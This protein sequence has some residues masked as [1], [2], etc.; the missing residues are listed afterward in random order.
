MSLM[1][2]RIQRPWTSTA[3][4]PLARTGVTGVS[5]IARKMGRGRCKE[6]G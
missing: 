4:G 5:V 6:N 1:A 2:S 3:V